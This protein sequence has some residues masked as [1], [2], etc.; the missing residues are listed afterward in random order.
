MSDFA[1]YLRDVEKFVYNHKGVEPVFNKKE[2][3]DEF[4]LMFFFG[5]FDGFNEDYGVEFDW[6]EIM[7]LEI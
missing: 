7:S 2:T 5:W 3:P 6:D 4:L 1:Y